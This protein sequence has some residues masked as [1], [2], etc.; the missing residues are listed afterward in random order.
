MGGWG[1]RG[2]WSAEQS[3]H[4]Q[5]F[6]MKFAVLHGHDLWPPKSIRRERSLITDHHNGYD[7]NNNKVFNIVRITKM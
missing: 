7:N 2:G 3:A 1:R 6:S 4:T 5:Q